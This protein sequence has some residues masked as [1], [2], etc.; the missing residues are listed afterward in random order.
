MI[1]P[2]SV[3]GKDGQVAPSNRI[4]LAGVGLGP[5][6]RKVLTAFLKHKD[7]QFVAVA[8]PQTSRRE[9]IR[10]MAAK[11]SRAT[12]KEYD[13]NHFEP[14]YEPLFETFVTEQADFLVENLA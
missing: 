6:G 7:V 8:D 5:R 3:L 14:Y 13:C 2:S 11:M 1:V 9:I 4:V 10:K 12:L